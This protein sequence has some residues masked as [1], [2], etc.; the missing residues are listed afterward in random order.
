[1][2]IRFLEEHKINPVNDLVTVTVID[3]PMIS[4]DP[5]GTSPAAPLYQI[6]TPNG[7][8]VQLNFQNGPISEVGVNGVTNEALIVVVLDRMR[9][10]QKNPQFACRENAL[11]ITKLEEALHW[12]H[13]RTLAR[14]RKGIE[15]TRLPG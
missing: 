1:M 8:R 3:G 11:A 5:A 2:T 15:G 13:A 12:L 14:M 6:E 10:F 4:R 9:E 7:A